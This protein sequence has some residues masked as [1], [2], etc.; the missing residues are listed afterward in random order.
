[1]QYIVVAINYFTKWVEGK[2]L[3]STTPVKIKEFIYR[4]IIYQYRVPHIIVSDNITQFNYDQFKEFCND[5]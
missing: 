3:A 4:N 5:L 2:V 1:M